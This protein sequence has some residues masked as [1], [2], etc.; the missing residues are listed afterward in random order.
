MGGKGCEWIRWL[1]V[2]PDQ[3][4]TGDDHERWYDVFYSQ[5][6]DVEQRK[7]P[8]PGQQDSEFAPV[9]ALLRCALGLVLGVGWGCL[10]R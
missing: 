6:E 7:P 9:C 5:A 1:A 3:D 8:Y 2:L 10:G 4:Y